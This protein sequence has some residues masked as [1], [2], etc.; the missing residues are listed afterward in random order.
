[1]TTPSRPWTRSTLGTL[2]RGY[3]AHDF[4][5]YV[6][7]KNYSGHF[8]SA[9]FGKHVVYEGLLGQSWLWLADF[10]HEITSIA[11]QPTQVRGP[12]GGRTRTRIPDF[13][14]L[15]ST[16]SVRV[17]DVKPAATSAGRGPAEGCRC[18]QEV[19]STSVNLLVVGQMWSGPLHDDQRRYSQ[20]LVYFEELM[21]R[22]MRH[23]H[24]ID[25]SG[26]GELL[27]GRPASCHDLLTPCSGNMT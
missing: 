26:F 24:V 6:G 2:R 16:G 19:R 15:T 21:R 25:G 22:E 27:D 10:A 7:R 3:Q 11:A 1:M 5:V 4:P 14:C 13:M 9:T 12:D 17:V 23:V 8:W 20:K 18:A